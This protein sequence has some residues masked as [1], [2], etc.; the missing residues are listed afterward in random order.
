[1]KP[2]RKTGAGRTRVRA[3]AAGPLDKVLEVCTQ[4]PGLGGEPA[5]A[6]EFVAEAARKVFLAALSG[7]LLRQGDSYVLEAVSSAPKVS[8]EKS[9]LLSHVTSFASLAIE[10]NRLVNFRF[11]YQDGESERIYHGLALPLVTTQSAAALLLARS[12]SFSAAELSAFNVLGNS[13][14]MAL[15]NLELAALQALRD[16][17]FSN[18]L[19]LYGDLGDAAS[20]DTFLEKFVVRAASTL[21]FEAAF[22]AAVE[23]GG[24]YLRWGATPHSRLDVSALARRVLEPREHFVTEDAGRLPVPEKAQLHNWN[25]KARQ[26]LALPLLSSDS[27]PLGILGLVNKKS[28]LPITAEEIRRAR[29][30]SCG[31]AMALEGRRNLQFSEQHK[32]RAEDLMEMALDLGSVLRLP[33]FVRTFTERVAAMIGAHTAILALAQGSSVESVG[34]FGTKPERELLRRLNTALSEF[35]E[36][37]ADIKITGSGIQILGRELSSA[38]GWQNVTLVRLEGTDADLLGVL[39]L[40]DVSRELLPGDLNLLQALIV[41]GSVA[42]ENSRLFTRI[43]QSSRQWLEIFDS[44]SDFIV[45]HDE[46]YKVLKVN[47]SLA[48][49]IG[50]RPAELIGLNMRALTPVTSDSPDPCP[51]CRE[52]EGSDEYLHPV[53]ERSY[54]VSSSR[55]NGALDEGQQTVHILKDIT[56]RREAERRYR[57]LFDN[58]QEGVFFSSPEGH[59]IEVNDALVRMLGYGSRE[60]VLQLDLNAQVYV[61]SEQRDEIVRRLEEQGSVRNFEMTLRRCDGSIIHALENAFVVRDG[62]NRILQYRGVLLDITEVKNFQA[63][64]Q[65]ERDFT[66]KILNNTQTMIMVADTAGLIS[67]ANR[68]CHESGHFRQNE[69]VGNRLDSIISSSYQ[70]AFREGFDTALHGMQVDNL[71]L[72]IIRGNGSQGKFSVNISPMRDEASDVNSV[73]VLMTDI[74]DASMIQAK[75][76]HTEKMAAVG[77]LVSGVAHEVNNPLTAIM[78]FSDLLMEN[79]EVPGSARKDLQ[80][81]LEE[82]QRTKEIVQNLLSFA[83]QRPPQRQRLQINDILRKTIALRAYDFSNHGVQIVENFDEGLPELIGDSHQ[84]QQVFLNILNNAYDAVHSSGRAGIIEIDT[85]HDGSWVEVLFRDNGEGIRHPERIFDPFFTTKEVGQGT[86]LGLSICYGIVRE[87][88]GEILCANNQDTPGATFSVRLPVRTKADL[89]VMTTAT[90]ARQ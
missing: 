84:L 29:I 4:L 39:A 24:C 22:V 58:V 65:R 63:Q 10:Q 50:V 52:Q 64:L 27:V 15:D 34:F 49:F 45:V 31:A 8:P 42:L 60:E 71:E 44:I 90:G 85:I 16:K 32:K 80:V 83:R 41:N 54:L 36:Y 67:Y 70:Q 11:S 30:L 46:H 21:G 88:E 78:G 73:V 6:R 68:R 69:L 87:H 66:G 82:A 43:A 17:D 18:L 33:D 26:Y 55:M 56:D 35:G 81:I 61:S 9:V 2:K 7:V 19:D 1:M 28:A 48:E 89:K 14:R 40:A 13:A 20:Q 57:E 51:F 3:K 77:Q 5:V 75:L 72:M 76:M 79:P 37:H 53:L 38:L 25:A 74:T 12:T 62:Q 86:G 23:A 59:F 47:R